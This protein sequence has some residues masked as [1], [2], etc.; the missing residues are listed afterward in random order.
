MD[1]AG[2][3]S[4]AS[5]ALTVT[6]N[7]RGSAMPTITSFSTDS[8]VVGDGITNDNTP[9]LT[10][11]A[12]ANSTV[13]VYDGSTLLGTT[14]ANSSGA[15]TSTT[16]QLSNGTHQITATA[17][18]SSGSTSSSFPDAST[19]GVPAGTKLTTVN[20]NFTSSSNGQIIDGL[21]V[22]GT[23]IIN[24]AGVTVQNCHAGLIVIAAPNVTIQDCTVVGINGSATSESG[25]VIA[26]PAQLGGSG[27]GTADGA[28][29]L[30]CNISGVE[31]GIWLEG[32]GALIQDNYIHDL[33][34]PPTG[35]IDGL[36][37][38]NDFP[39]VANATIRHNN[40][41]QGL[42]TESSC[43][44]ID[45]GH[46]FIIDN[47]RFYGGSYELYLLSRESGTTQNCLIINNLFVANRFG[48][49]IDEQPFTGL[50]FYRGNVDENGKPVLP[51]A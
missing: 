29:I 26:S 2:N 24:N 3:T 49:A 7:T 8:G 18:T 16:S 10:G 44:Q 1:V 51:N 23:I 4:V 45:N 35:H 31:N 25:I 19:T 34:A 5:A 39:G 33:H 15:W 17:T 46:N 11:T 41:D 50:N 47:N 14:T 38:P 20:G 40:F 32:N 37:V 12:P 30:R 22:S 43:I 13:Q 28:T 36:Q 27:S 9:T 48:G 6:V 21:N 42:G